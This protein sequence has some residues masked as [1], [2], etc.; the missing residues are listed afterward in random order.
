MAVIDVVKWNATPDVYAWR[1]P[2]DELATWTQLIVAETQEAIMMREGR[3]LGPFLPGR[4]TLSTKNIPA[5]TNFL[6]IPFGARTP[7]T[8]EVWFVN[9]VIGLD[10]KWGT[11]NPIQVR[12]PKY[13]VMLPIRAFGQFGLR[14]AHT[15]KFLVKLVG[16]LPSFDR[17]HMTSY[18]RGIM[19]TRVKDAVAKQ[20]VKQGV[21]I[22]EISA[23]L[24]ELSAALQKEMDGEF[25]EFGVEILKFNI[26]SIDTPEDDPAVSRLRDALARRAEM[27]IVGYTYQ[28][29]RSF[30]TLE[31]AAKNPGTGGAVM[32]AGLG[33]G[34]GVAVGGPMGAAM[35]ALSKNLQA[36][37][38]CPKCG[39]GIAG[40]AK[41]CSA[42]GITVTPS[43]QTA[44]GAEDGT[45]VC[46]KCGAWAP[47]G[48]KFCPNCSDPFVCCPKCGADN[49]EGRLNCIKC[50]EPMPIRCGNCN[51]EFPGGTRFCPKCGKPL[52]GKC[53]KCDTTM[54]PQAKFCPNCGASREQGGASDGT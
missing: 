32:G 9:K 37:V 13:D 3:I 17:E 7:F 42:C 46:D 6:K 12:D 20:L 27:K 47:K 15:K 53:A 50:G 21:S 34:M 40:D 14:I 10:V 30:D 24:N 25:S 31:G 29:E 2:S 51:Q 38:V 11:P 45:L 22:L 16:T 18:F 28:Q 44:Q 5:L 4:H 8:A 35:G 36:G 33:L 1:F 52:L 19:T 23:L 49:P 54:P 41:F 48:S 39:A 26:I 43:P